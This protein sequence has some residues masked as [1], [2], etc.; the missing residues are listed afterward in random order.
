MDMAYLAASPAVSQVVGVDGIMKAL[1]EF[2]KE[3]PQLELQPA[4]SVPVSTSSSSSITPS[5]DGGDDNSCAFERLR[6]NKIELLRGDFFEL[7]EQHTAGRFDVIFDRASI[8]AIQP[9]LREK[10]VAVMGKLVQPGGKILLVTIVRCSGDA[11]QD[12]SSGPPFSVT[13]EEVRRL[14]EGNEWVESVTLLDNAGEA[15]RNA[16]A[17]M[18]S[19][20]FCIQ[21]KSL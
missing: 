18:T 16:G 2:A 14:Y 9:A 12:A 7:D 13:E 8:V 19:L 17:G 11:V 6:G 21:A 5:G 3:H 15:S 4:S 10:Y 20:F 1:Q